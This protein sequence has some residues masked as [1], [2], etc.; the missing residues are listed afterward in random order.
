MEEKMGRLG[1]RSCNPQG[2]HLVSATQGRSK[3]VICGYYSTLIAMRAQ[4]SARDIEYETVVKCEH[5]NFRGHHK[6]RGFG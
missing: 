6:F 5:F 4:W 2:R 3:V 1:L